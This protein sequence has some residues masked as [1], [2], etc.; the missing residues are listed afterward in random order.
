MSAQKIDLPRKY[1]ELEKKQIARLPRPRANDFNGRFRLALKSRLPLEGE[2]MGHPE[3]LSE[4]LGGML[5]SAT[6]EFRPGK[7]VLIGTLEGVDASV[8]SAITIIKRV[9]EVHELAFIMLEARMEGLIRDMAKNERRPIMWASEGGGRPKVDFN[10]LAEQAT[11]ERRQ[12]AEYSALYSLTEAVKGY[13]D[14]YFDGIVL[15]S[16]EHG[17]TSISVV[18][19]LK[20]TQAKGPHAQ[21][22]RIGSCDM[23]H[24][25]SQEGNF[26]NLNNTAFLAVE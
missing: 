2:K 7:K 19:E 25:L 26:L 9:D 14:T 1:K 16:P 8:T 20:Q 4:V 3:K 10:M 12:K 23:W 15:F 6:L 18:V 21:I 5:T 17:I 24:V 11:M 22:K 13:A